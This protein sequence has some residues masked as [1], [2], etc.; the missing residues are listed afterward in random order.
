MCDLMCA[1]MFH[2]MYDLMCA[3]MYHLMCDLICAM[4]CDLM[5]AMMYDLNYDLMY[6]LIC[7]RDCEFCGYKCLLCEMRRVFEGQRR[8]N[9]CGSTLVRQ[10]RKG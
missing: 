9:F 8:Q 3:L 2:L 7:E 5:C 6:H 4:M 1:L 10:A